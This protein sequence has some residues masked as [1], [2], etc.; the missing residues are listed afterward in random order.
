LTDFELI[1]RTLCFSNGRKIDKE[2]DRE[3]VTL[4]GGGILSLFFTANGF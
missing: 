3:E 4:R 2:I 1:E